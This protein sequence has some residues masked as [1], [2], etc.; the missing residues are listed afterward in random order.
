[1][2]RNQDSQESWILII[3]KLKNEQNLFNEF[4]VEAIRSRTFVPIITPHCFFDLQ[5]RKRNNQ[6]LPLL[7][8]YWKELHSIKSGSTKLLLSKSVEG[9]IH[10]LLRNIIG[11]LNP[12]TLNE[13]SLK[14]IIMSS[15]IDDFMEISWVVVS[16]LI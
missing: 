1:M 10:S 7:L 15:E 3:M 16:F 4:E 2:P 6:K 11:V 9:K 13:K 14:T 12:F 5:I 8:V